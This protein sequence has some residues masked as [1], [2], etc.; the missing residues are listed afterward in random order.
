MLS[1]KQPDVACLSV[2][3]GQMQSFCQYLNV[4][5]NNTVTAFIRGKQDRNV[6]QGS[7]RDQRRK[8]RH[9][10]RR[11]EYDGRERIGQDRMGWDDRERRGVKRQDGMGQ[12][13]DWCTRVS[14]GI[15]LWGNTGKV[16]QKYDECYKEGI[17]RVNLENLREE[18]SNKRCG[19]DS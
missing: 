14:W 8:D 16:L 9:M 12:D 5:V 2:L 7:T 10:G 4:E 18:M 17:K 11:E 3:S 19:L 1:F 13:R 15:T 6:R